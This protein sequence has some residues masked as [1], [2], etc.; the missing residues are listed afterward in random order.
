MTTHHSVLLALALLGAAPLHAQ[1]QEEL[2]RRRDEKLAE[3]WLTKAPWTTA[4]ADALE[5][6]RATGKPIFAYFSRSYAP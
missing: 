2:V 5:R 1:T 4:Y 6:A 3:E